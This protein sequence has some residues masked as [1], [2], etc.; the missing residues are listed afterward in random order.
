MGHLGVSS[1]S[2]I[3]RSTGLLAAALAGVVVV[4]VHVVF[5]DEF[6]KNLEANEEE[7][8]AQAGPR[9]RRDVDPAYAVAAHSISLS[10]NYDT[11]ASQPS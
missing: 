10:T 7:Q 6:E 1:S 5:I 11:L 4:M 9:W 2:S 8:E 3:C